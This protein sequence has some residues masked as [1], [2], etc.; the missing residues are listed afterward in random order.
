MRGPQEP[1]PGERRDGL[2]AGL[3][4][5]EAGGPV[6]A[7]AGRVLAD[8][9]ARVVGID[10]GPRPEGEGSVDFWALH[11]EHRAVAG[12]GDLPTELAAADVVLCEASTGPP[13]WLTRQRLP[14]ALWVTIS[15]YGSSGPRARW[16]GSEL[17]CLA[18]SGNLYVTG[19]PDRPPAGCSRPTATPHAG[20]EAA[21]AA[22]FGLAAGAREV[23]MSAQE[24]VMSANM[25]A[26]GAYPS[27]GFVPKRV[28]NFTG[29]TQEIWPTR[30]GQISY[31]VRGGA[32]RARSWVALRELMRAEG[33]DTAALPAGDAREFNADT[34][35]DAQLAEL[36]AVLARFFGCHTSDELYR[37]ALERRIMLAPVLDAA[38]IARHPQLAHRE[39]FE[40][41]PNGM[42]VPAR[43]LRVHEPV[44]QPTAAPAGVPEPCGSLARAWAGLRVLELGSAFA[45]PLI[46]RYF[47]EHGATCVRV[48]SAHQLDS[49]RV[50]GPFPVDASLPVTERSPA[51]PLINAG[52]LSVRSNAKSAEGLA[53]IRRLVIEWADLVIENFTAGVLPRWG[54]GYESVSAQ[55][56]DLVM[57]STNLWG[58]SG[59]HCHEAGYGGQ[60]QAMSGHVFL[61]GWP[62]RL[63]VGPFGMITDSLS[64]RL[65]A[66]AGA[67]ALRRR[68]RTGAGCH[69]D[70]SQV[71]SSV[72]SL[73]QWFA[74]WQRSGRMP[75]RQGNDW[76]PDAI[77]HGVFPCRGDDSWI[78]IATWTPRD[79]EAL[80][81]ILGGSADGDGPPVADLTTAW[82]ADEL[83][84]RLQEADVE[85][86]RVHDHASLH[87][88]PQLVTRRHFMPFR[89][90]L[91]GPL[92]YERCGFRDAGSDSDPATPGD[93]PAF[94]AHTETVLRQ[95]LGLTDSEIDSLREHGALH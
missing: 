39:S 42:R 2:L 4:V 27:T 85:A 13:P 40:T 46:G 44:K 17:T 34:L 61:T 62:D 89:H 28:G 88:D 50:I 59:P 64:A 41:L 10:R 32:G 43:P 84:E 80:L 78:A 86:Y 68:A 29:R 81:A 45:G 63:P 15:P 92:R 69:I 24:A 30:D 93:G 87:G 1:P 74:D 8:L 9:G 20:V 51:F 60:G 67:A 73:G 31:G 58:V 49:M 23:D 33:H 7:I 19:D 48:E 90:P 16:R 35:S 83:A 52:K 76:A 77:T 95:I 26:P 56:P 57:I 94:G 71:E 72:W 54:L 18:A 55:R 66:A 21:V 22:L 12:P 79:Q 6:A 82:D 14:R 36:T 91:P 75:G 37:W 65:G 25:T 53:L 11:K 38:G 5:I 47:T 70:I 3:L